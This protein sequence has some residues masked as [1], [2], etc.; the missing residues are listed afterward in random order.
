MNGIIVLHMLTCACGDLTHFPAGRSGCSVGLQSLS[1]DN[2]SL[3]LGPLNEM[4][5]IGLSRE[6]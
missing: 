5:P 3:A 2:I 4:D 1:G 6:S